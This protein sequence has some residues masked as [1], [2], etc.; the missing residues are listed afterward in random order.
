LV[1]ILDRSETRDIPQ[2]ESIIGLIIAYLLF[3]IPGGIL[4]LITA[5]A[6]FLR[7]ARL[8]K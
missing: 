5:R 4:F 8:E 6:S 7:V 1:D 3:L 2:N